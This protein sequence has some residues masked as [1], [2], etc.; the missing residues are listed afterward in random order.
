[1]CSGELGLGILIRDATDVSIFIDFFFAK[2]LKHLNFTNI[3][4]VGIYRSRK[5]LSYLGQL[6]GHEF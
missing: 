2:E 5:G 6:P 4:A 1:M 3:A